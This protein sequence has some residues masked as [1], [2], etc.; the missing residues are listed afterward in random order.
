M[1]LTVTL[2]TAVDVTYRLHRVHRHGS[3][4]VREVAER[5]GGKGINVARI[6]HAIGHES[7]VTGLAGGVT[8]ATVRADLAASGLRDELMTI[9]GHT[10]R[11]VAVAEDRDGDTTIYLEPGPVVTPEEWARFLVRYERLLGGA[12]AVVL[13]G[14]LPT[15]LPHD[16][17][18][19]LVSLA[20]A[21]RVPAVLDADGAAL[22]GGLPAGP[23]LVK[24]NA[25][26]L[27]TATGTTDPRAGAHTLLARGALA[28]VASLGPDG[29][30]ATTP[31]GSWQARPPGK[32]HG[33]P[34]GAGD[35]AVAA[36]TA[37]LVDDT[38]WPERLGQAVALSA[39]TVLAPLAGSFDHAAYHRMLP[40]I[41]VR[42]LDPTIPQGESWPS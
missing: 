7:V 35:S 12:A 23:A 10:R 39:A 30:L 13:S 5:A 34:T 16:A 2:N 19:L 18:G 31:E 26:E 24:P 25:H 4:R 41:Q 1:I 29:L 37:G 20:K 42:P 32:V 14:S 33:N 38:P 6:L 27:A 28:V 21:R 40:L 3:N 15:G 36:L 8:G 22:R 11:T 17:Y 9:D